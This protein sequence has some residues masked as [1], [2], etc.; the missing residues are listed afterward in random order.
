MKQQNKNFLYNIAYQLLTF[1][2]PIILTPY[3]SR[4]LGVSNVGVYSYSYS[5]VY[6]FMLLTMLGINNYGTREVAKCK[7]REERSKTFRSI[8]GLQSICGLISFVAYAL[9][10]L[11]YN[12]DHKEILIIN[13]VFLLS[14]I[15]DINWFFFGMEKFKLTTTRNMIIKILSMILVFALVKNESQLPLYTLILSGSILISQ[16]YMW[17]FLRREIVKAKITAKDIF[18]H[19]KPCLIFF[20]PVISYSIYRVMDKTMIGAMASS[21]ELGNYESAEKIINIPV[22]LVTAL[23]TV[24]LPHMSKKSKDEIKESIYSTF[25]LTAFI[26]IPSA[27]AIAVIAQDFS[28]LF[29]G[30]GF[31]KTGAILQALVCTIVFSGIANVI[32]TNFLI[33]LKKDKIYVTSTILGAIINLAFNAVLIPFFGAYGACVGTIL[34]EFSLMFYQA[35][36]TGKEIHYSKVARIFAKYMVIGCAMAAA[37]ILVSLL[38]VGQLTKVL[39]QLAAGAVV[40][41]VICHHYIIEDFLGRKKVKA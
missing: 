27:I 33:P 35:I 8:Y 6:Y 19:L 16:L 30:D 1:I 18:K 24:M 41:C 20:I 15:F 10:V 3:V 39:L 4:V 38:N 29:F 21:T 9:L 25:E 37:M 12:Y 23:G 5:I 7:S 22:S 2:I 34:A 36:K 17:L 32:R 40:Y 14:A 28:V 26:T 11:L 13:S 31:D